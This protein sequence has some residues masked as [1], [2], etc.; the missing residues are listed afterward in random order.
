MKIDNTG[1]PI[2]STLTRLAEGKNTASSK[3]TASTQQ[4]SVS[5]N[6]L[7]AKIQA[8][9]AAGTGSTFDADKVAAI[10]Q[11]ISDGKF[12]VRADAIADKLVS[13]VQELLKE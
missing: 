6:P 4:E 8:L 5:I 2:A 1:K 13:S 9:E 10:R 12:T 3:K 11:A 7:A